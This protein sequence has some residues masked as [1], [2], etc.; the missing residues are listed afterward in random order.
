MCT[1]QGQQSSP[2]SSA[3]SR[4]AAPGNHLEEQREAFHVKERRVEQGPFPAKCH[5]CNSTK[6]AAKTACYL[7]VVCLV[8]GFKKHCFGN[9]DTNKDL[10]GFVHI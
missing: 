9:K 10:N 5:R 8:N 2:T 3:E 1:P 7:Y 6:V 4:W